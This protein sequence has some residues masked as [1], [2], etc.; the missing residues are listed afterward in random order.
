MSST[1]YTD[2]F[3]GESVEEGARWTAPAA[4]TEQL[5]A[6][7]ATMNPRTLNQPAT[8]GGGVATTCRHGST[9]LVLRI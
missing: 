3:R 9:H 8:E 2:E 6:N 5:N 1:R 7:A 4:Y